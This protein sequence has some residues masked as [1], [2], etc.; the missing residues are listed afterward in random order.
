MPLLCLLS[1]GLIAQIHGLFL[2]V[3][4]P[5]HPA[6]LLV[7]LVDD[8]RVFVGDIALPSSITDLPLVGGH[9]VDKAGPLAVA[10]HLVLLLVLV[11]AREPGSSGR[12][13]AVA[14][15][16]VCLNLVRSFGHDVLALFA[17]GL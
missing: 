11:H 10:H 4:D 13:A 17:R 9:E 6:F 2:E 15:V 14:V 3:V 5:L 12:P 7:N 8:L 1:V 16:L